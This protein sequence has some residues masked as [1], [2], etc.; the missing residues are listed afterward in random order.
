MKTHLRPGFD[1]GMSP[2]FALHRTSSGCILR[3]LAACSSVSVFMVAI[4]SCIGLREACERRCACPCHEISID[5]RIQMHAD[6]L[7]RK[8]IDRPVRALATRKAQWADREPHPSKV[9]AGTAICGSGTAV[10]S[11]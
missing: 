10:P 1:A 9:S 4:R 7:H 8:I 2:R 11:D 5:P 6:D 3:N